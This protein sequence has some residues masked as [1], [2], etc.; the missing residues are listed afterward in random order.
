MSM[1]V[2][3]LYINIDINQNHVANSHFAA[4]ASIEGCAHFISRKVNAGRIIL[5]YLE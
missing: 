3:T 1:N 4:G 5:K 2:Y